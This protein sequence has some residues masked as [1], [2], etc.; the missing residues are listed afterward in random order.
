MV[1]QMSLLI[2]KVQVLGLYRSVI[3]WGMSICF[4][5]KVERDS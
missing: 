4:R 3:M 5:K 2:L 1:G